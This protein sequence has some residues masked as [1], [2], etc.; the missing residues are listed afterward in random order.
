[1]ESGSG[2]SAQ[3]WR[4]E[5]RPGQHSDADPAADPAT[6]ESGAP[7][8]SLD[9]TAIVS[10]LLRLP[11]QAREVFLDRACGDDAA[12]RARIELLMRA[13]LDAEEFS[14]SARRALGD[15]IAERACGDDAAERRIQQ[16][17]A[18]TEECAIHEGPGTRVGP[19]KILQRIG[20]G[21]FGVVFMAEQEKPVRRRVALK[22][23]KLGMDTRQV[24]ARFEAERQALAM[25]DHPNIARVFDAGATDT[26][27]PYFVMEL[28]RA[29]SITKYCDDQKLSIPE[30]L[31]LFIPVCRAVQHAHQRGVIHRDIKPGNVLV[32]DHDGTPVPKVIDFGIAKA[33]SARLTDRT[34]FTAFRDF[35]GTPEYMSPEQATFNGLDIDTRTD[36]YS[37][38]ALLYELL[39]GATPFD[40]RAMRA[41]GPEEIQRMIRD[42][43][44][45]APSTRMSRL[46]DTQSIAVR[47]Q[48]DPDAM[49]R[50][51]RGDLDWIVMCCL[52][53]DRTRRYESPSRLADD[54]ERHLGNRPIEAGPPSATY[55]ISKFV[56][57]H[58]AAVVAASVVAGA[59][60]CG[61][62]VATFGLWR[63]TQERD[64]ARLAQQEAEAAQAQVA[65]LAAEEREVS[66][67]LESLFVKPLPIH[68]SAAA[69]RDHI[70]ARAEAVFGRGDA[71]VA[72]LLAGVGAVLAGDVAREREA[73]S[74]LHRAISY[75]QTATSTESVAISIPYLTLAR[76]RMFS[77]PAEAA[78]FARSAVSAC[79]RAF[80]A[81]SLETACARESL[82]LHLMSGGASRDDQGLD[83]LEASCRQAL[84]TYERIL[85]PGHARTIDARGGLGQALYLRGRLTEAEPLLRESLAR[86]SVNAD[87]QPAIRFSTANILAELLKGQRRTA[88]AGP[89]YLELESAASEYLG[90]NSPMY[91]RYI[92]A[93]IKELRDLGAFDAAEK[94]SGRL[95][96]AESGHG[97]PM[98]VR[99]AQAKARLGGADPEAAAA[100][101]RTLLKEMQAARSETSQAAAEDLA[102]VDLR[103]ELCV[104]AL[105]VESLTR[106]GHH[107]EAIRIAQE[108]VASLQKAMG[109]AHPTVLESR[110]I[111]A[112]ALVASGDRDGGR[113]ML[114]SVT[115]DLLSRSPP[116]SAA[117]LAALRRLRALS[118]E[119]GDEAEEE[120]I[121]VASLRLVSAMNAAPAAS[122]FDDEEIGAAP[123]SWLVPA[124]SES[125]GTLATIVPVGAD[126]TGRCLE[127]SGLGGVDAAL[128]PVA[129][130][131]NVMQSFDATPYRGKT[132]R[133]RALVRVAVQPEDPRGRAQ[134][135]IRADRP[136]S[137]NAGLFDNMWDRPIRSP[138]WEEHEIV[139][140]VD[141]DAETLSIGLMAFGEAGVW[142][143]DVRFEVV[144]SATL[145]AHPG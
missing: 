2:E 39:V 114:K 12:S 89:V 143:D 41:R 72:A 128:L 27:R 48:S 88:E 67:L 17:A 19:Y 108:R 142:M 82:A 124:A 110:A 105:L 31:K 102:P 16:A 123:R 71:N 77:N 9:I 100:E 113:Q 86:A 35:I 122:G 53:K 92:A 109:P 20:E 57:R 56:R 76:L 97:L 42:D 91:R 112:E 49:R 13:R 79:Q 59:L 74:L 70:E 111:L 106:A 83:E 1:M 107:V 120:R 145:D 55:R 18:Y 98:A 15:R 94:L 66:R 5:A 37:L 90:S 138:E 11:P 118:R 46:A 125:G 61:L 84:T 29:V 44:P 93:C 54:I 14:P 7:E 130:F 21:G 87:V 137:A 135:W 134:L 144:E 115:E 80:G 58:R 33:T 51:L 99:Y 3:D 50:A 132:V 32:S 63:A 30:R 45:V 68:A 95:Q 62:A 8:R 60:V 139:G 117:A 65:E 81:D 34:L 28:V 36:V 119:D 121:A 140:R 133:L 24:V 75:Q 96:A 47:R 23:I 136:H 141:D 10:A 22:I 116:Q 43:D 25:M 101:C 73:S 103:R 64:A 78:D 85:G 38:G 126:G 131:R 4:H 104:E 6:N 127:L 129:G 40:G 26:G 52:Q 69:L